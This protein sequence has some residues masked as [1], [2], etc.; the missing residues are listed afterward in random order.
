MPSKKV[1][2]QIDI[3]INVSDDLLNKF[4]GAMLKMNSMSSMGALPMMLGQM[5]GAPENPPE[6]E[7]RTPIGFRDGGDNENR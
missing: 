2:N 1:N 7:E 3:S 4:V 6:S 5:M